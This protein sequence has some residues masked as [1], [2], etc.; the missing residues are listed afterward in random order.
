MEVEMAMQKDLSISTQGLNYKLRIAV[1]LMAILPLLVCLYLVSNYILPN[2]GVKVDIVVS[3]VVSIFIA[4]VGFFFIKEV[5]DHVLSVTSA[6]KLIAAGDINCKVETQYNDEVGDLGSALNQLTDRMRSNMEELKTFSEKTTEI[7]MAIKENVLVLS[8]L[9]QISSLISQ[10]TEIDDIL[11][12][13]IQNSRLLAY[14]DVAY[15][16]FRVEN[17]DMFIMKLVEGN[18]VAGL[19]EITIK[20]E[21]KIFSNYIFKKNILIIDKENLLPEDE[22]HGFG[23]KFGLKN[24]LALPVYLKGRM[25][26]I[27]GIGNSQEGFLY[28]KTDAELLELFAK[29]IAIALENDMLTQRVEKLEIKD[30]LTGLY[31]A[32]FIRNRLQE[33]IKRAIIYQRP[34]AFILLCIDNFQEFQ[35]NFGDLQ[36]ELVLKKMTSL[37]RHSVSEIESIARFEDDKFCIVLPEK[38]KRQAL[39]TAENIRKKIEFIFSEEQDIKKRLTLS[40]SISENPLD[41]IDAQELIN[42]AQSLLNTNKKM[43]IYNKII[44]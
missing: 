15:L 16:L 21:E 42:K 29:L 39:E 33:E 7:N 28:K 12:I 8:S 37:I 36:T 11:K 40:G 35:L 4:F 41:G 34:C 17:Q 22:E 5:F 14:S 30:A 31:N 43:R 23:E 18:I 38:N 26:A 3:I 13:A 10:G 6:A 1:Y 19:S 32:M 25:I 2:V 9:L 27:I 20:T 44:S 24:T